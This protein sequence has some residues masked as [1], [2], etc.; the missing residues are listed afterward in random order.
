MNPSLLFIRRPIMTTLVMSSLIFFG[1]FAYTKLPVSD[2]PNVDYPTISVSASL[3]GASPETMA[4]SVATPLEK[5]FSTIAG[6]DS[7][8]SVNNLGSTQITIQFNLDRDIDAAALDVQSAI[9]KATRLLPSDMPAPPSYQK[10]N[11]ADQPILYMGLTSTTLP[12]SKVNE[13][14]ET[15]ISQRLATLSGVAQVQIMGAQKYAVRIN[16][17]PDRLASYGISLDEVARAI[18]SSNVNLP[19][20]T[21][22]G[23][24]TSFTV[25]TD[26]QL[27]TAKDYEP[28][29][30]AYRN[31]SPIRLRDVGTARDG[32]EDERSAA[33]LTGTRGIMMSIQRQPGANTVKVV[34]EVRKALPIIEEQ[35][36]PSI[37]L[38]VMFDRS[39]TIRH[40]I[41][42]VQL[43]LI[44][45]VVLVIAVIFIFLR[46]ISATIIPGLAV[47][48][49]IIGTFG[50]MHLLGAGV[51]NLS[52]MALTLSVGFVVD[53]AIVMLENIVR[54]M[55]HGEPGMEASINGSKEI[56]FTI[57]SM[58]ISLV[59]VFLPVLFLSGIIGR[60][61]HEFAIVISIAIL[62][63][64]VVSLTLT[65]MLC[66]RFLRAPDPAKTP[67]I[68]YRAIESVFEGTLGLYRSTLKLAMKLRLLM[69]L[70][71]FALFA[72]TYHFF[73]AIPKGFIPDEDIGS[74]F[75]STEARQ[76]ISFEQ[77]VEQQKIAAEMVRRHP[78]V[79]NVMSSVSSGGGNAANTGRIFVRLKDRSEREPAGKVLEDLRKEFA[80]IP[81]LK[82]FLQI[83]PVIR[84]GGR[85]SKSQYQ[86]TLLGQD[87]EELNRSAQELEA[88]MNSMPELQDVSSDLQLKNPEIR[89][90]ID[91]ERASSLGITARDVEQ[92][93][94][95]AYGT[96]RVSTIF[97][98]NNQYDV[99]M[100]VG[101]KF[102]LV[103]ENLKD[104]YLRSS[105][106]EL[107]PLETIAKV[108]RSV[109]PLSVSHFGQLTAVTLSYNLKPGV[110][111]GQALDAVTAA[112]A[113]ILPAS[114]TM[115]P[116]G[117]AQVFKDSMSGLLLLVLMSL[118]VI[119]LILGILYESFIHPITILSGL[120]SAALGALLTL[121]LF[122][123]DLNL[124]GFVGIIMLVGIVKKNAI[125]MIDFAL[126]AQRNEGKDP[127]E[128][129]IQGCLVRFRPIMM[130]TAAALMGT[131]PIA[132][133]WGAGAESRRPLGLAVVGGLAV[134]Q[135]LT[136]YFTPVYFLY[137]E[138]LTRGLKKL[139]ARFFPPKDDDKGHGSFIQPSVME[140]EDTGQ[141]V[142][143]RELAHA[144]VRQQPAG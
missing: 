7:M 135:L 76:G 105:N 77:M 72:V 93:L 65:P 42:D 103:P 113:E 125:M 139:R 127:E 29:I 126:E 71:S 43:T 17:D 28:V 140:I 85:L 10:V 80:T 9:G 25:Q 45:T 6:I 8:S 110:A 39:Q 4:S 55:E 15:L 104:L 144:E 34:D 99:I 119:Y 100:E 132:L 22:Y 12:L 98:P 141:P 101:K 142:T 129:I 83:P 120:P 31:G 21:L 79:E 114:V 136:L 107:V 46:N 51:N 2:L 32:V 102:Q 19:T 111:L 87:T 78:A 112:G 33:W 118:V 13:Y 14:A 20:G 115:V 49:S 30:I 24:A 1:W 91:R 74:L 26:G 23:K 89:V 133:G 57:V 52:L 56:A 68:F 44:G 108:E 130:T 97:A 122:K 90:S 63:S 64:G 96:R 75:G 60:L 123:S 69:L 70:I 62:L 81:G 35:L 143:E 41:D 66:S 86:M 38:K 59:A 3:P 18:D 134:S 11:P 54:R 128:A 117:T 88:R 48:L 61:L 131:L 82:V 92:T 5:Q 73:I 94:Y 138:K 50:F 36:P 37:E 53:D 137:F 16:V 106:G 27:L 84:I 124:Y 109:G 116:V 121:M 40:S 67:N 95:N 47:P 58:T